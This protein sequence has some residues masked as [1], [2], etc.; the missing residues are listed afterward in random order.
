[1]PSDPEDIQAG[2]A[3][4]TYL[5]DPEMNYA[6]FRNAL[7]DSG[8]ALDG[9]HYAHATLGQLAVLAAALSALTPVNP[10]IPN[11]TEKDV[12]NIKIVTPRP[13]KDAR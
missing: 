2:R 11:L 13:E 8:A 7:A 12:L 10:V 3:S 9:L 5:S 1:L 6:R 4:G